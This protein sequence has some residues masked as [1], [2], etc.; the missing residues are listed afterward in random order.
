MTKKTVLSAVVVIGLAAVAL[1]AFAAGPAAYAG[2]LPA[3]TLGPPTAE[4]DVGTDHT[5]TATV[6][7]MPQGSL[8]TFVITGPNTGALIACSPNADCTTDAGNTVSGTYTGDG[9]VGQDTIDA[10]VEIPTAGAS[11]VQQLGCDTATK[12]WVEPPTPTPTPTP[13]PTPTPTQAA[14]AAQLPE[15]G[16][17]PPA[18]S[19]FP[20]LA[21]TIVALGAFAV[22]GGLVLRRR[23]R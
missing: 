17:Q 10:C 19:D 15:T 6:S 22:A 14:P 23:A 18:G 11:A 8:V 5:V 1:L 13:S 16:A 21:V 20:W 4:N 2:I 3:L 12:D 7:G 9:G